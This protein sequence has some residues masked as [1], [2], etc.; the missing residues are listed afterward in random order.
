MILAFS[1]MKYPSTELETSIIGTIHDKYQTNFARFCERTS[2]FEQ[3]VKDL[4]KTKQPLELIFNATTV[5]EQC[6]P[7]SSEATKIFMGLRAKPPTPYT[8]E[9][10]GVTIVSRQKIAITFE[11]PH[12]PLAG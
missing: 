11:K 9:A 1:P 8:S 4:N 3:T 12:Q 2:Q 5:S 10:E 7:L 6:L